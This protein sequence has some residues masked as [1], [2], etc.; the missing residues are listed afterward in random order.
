MTNQ[1]LTIALHIGAHKTATTHLQRSLKHAKRALAAK[2]V[3][4]YGP[5]H[6]RSPGQTIPALFGFRKDPLAPAPAL[7]AKDQLAQMRKDADRIVISEENFIGALN[8][9][10]GLALKTRYKDA[11]NRVAAFAQA[12]GQDI[13][14]FLALRSPTGFLNSAYCQM[15]LGGRVQPVGMYQR[16]NPISSVDWLGLVTRLHRAKGVGRLTVWKY[17]DYEAVFPQVAKA[18]VG[19]QAADLVVP[20]PKHVNRGLSAE[21]VAYVLEQDRINPREALATAAR[22][23]LPVEEGLAPFDGYSAEQHHIGNVAYRDQIAAIEALE[24]VTFLRPDEA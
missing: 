15:L 10:R 11:E 4:Y 8:H 14:V 1:P 3:Q 18:L 2:G 20:R 23:M 9:P 21:A 19:P 16:R 22:K 7:P 12:V 13:D 24:G 5:T 6:F 17:E